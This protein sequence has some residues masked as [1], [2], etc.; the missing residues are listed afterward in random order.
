MGMSVS[1]NQWE[2]DFWEIKF[3]GSSYY[4]SWCW[5]FFIDM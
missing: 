1:E 3:W 4:F 5:E 2:L